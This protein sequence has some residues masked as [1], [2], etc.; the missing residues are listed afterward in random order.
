MYIT[1]LLNKVKVKITTG[2]IRLWSNLT[3]KKTIRFTEK[4][5]F[6]TMLG[7]TQSHSGPLNDI[8]GFIRLIPGSNNGDKTNIITGVDKI[9]FNCGC[10]N[11]S[12]VNGV[13]ETIL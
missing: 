8:E 2:D 6:Y 1:L 3:T 10:N 7:F 9:H 12:L 4:S 11:G 5:F 13:R